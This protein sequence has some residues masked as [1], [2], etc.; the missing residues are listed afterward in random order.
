MKKTIILSILASVFAYV[1]IA[2]ADI[3]LS[4]YAEWIAGSVDQPT[5]DS[6]TEHGIDMSGIDNGTYT[7]LTAG[8]SSTLDSGLEVSGTMTISPRDCLGDRQDNC[9]VV[10]HN[11][12]TISGGFGAISIG[13]RFAAGAAMLSRLTASGPTAEPDGANMQYFYTQGDG[14][15]GGTNETNYA[16]NDMKI[17]YTSNVY[18]GF[19]FAVSYSDF[20]GSHGSLADL[21]AQQAS[22]ATAAAAWGDYS[23]LLSVFGKYAMEMDGVGVELVYGQ[24]TGNAGRDVT[25]DYNDLSETAYSVL[26]TYGNFAADY[27]K[28]DAGDSGRPK[29][30]GSGNNEGTSICGTYTMGNLGL[31][32][33]SIDST[34]TNSSNQTN[35]NKMITYNAEY[36][37]GGGMSFS[38][39]YFDHEQ[40][41]NSVVETDADGIL[42]RLAIG[43]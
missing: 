18:S 42:T 1:N 41:E 5:A 31:G 33:C 30:D 26:L 11:F 21:N 39:T 37:L 10:N 24:L 27:R 28:N 32:A 7:R 17:L 38:A 34:F 6:S 2:K 19:S 40:T 4:G 23:D 25:T 14:T 13:E 3:S 20:T 35:E 29:N 15:Y 36:Q 12:V 16:S 8:Y 9:D 22:G 43:F